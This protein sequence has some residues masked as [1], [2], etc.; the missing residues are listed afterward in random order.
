[1]RAWMFLPLLVVGCDDQLLEPELEGLDTGAVLKA[2]GLG[3]VNGDT[4]YCN[5]VAQLCV[6]G[7]GDCDKTTQCTAGLTCATDVGPDWGFPTGWDICEG[8]H[9][10]N[11]V[12]DGNE[13]GLDCG[14]SCAPC[15]G[16][17]SGVLGFGTTNSDRTGD[18]VAATDG[19]MYIVGQ[20]DGSLTLSPTVTLNTNGHTSI[21][22][23]KYNASGVLQWANTYTDATF[24]IG[25]SDLK[26][27]I[28]PVTKDVA[29]GG[30]FAGTVDFGA[31]VLTATNTD[32]FVVVMDANGN[33]TFAQ[34]YGTSGL[35]RVVDV[36]HDRL[37]NLYI[38]ALFAT[39]VNFGGATLNTAGLSDFG[40]GKLSSTNAHLYSL[41]FGNAN[42]DVPIDLVV[43]Q[44]LR[45]L[46]TS[47]YSG[48]LTVLGTNLVALGG[49]DIAVIRLTST[50]AKSFVKSF[51]G[52][53]S[54][55]SASIAVNALRQP[56][57]AGYFK[58]TVDFGAG[59]VVSPGASKSDAFLLALDAA[60]VH[61]WSRI[62]S[63]SDN[64]QG[65]IVFPTSTGGAAFG[66]FFRG[67]VTG[68][69]VDG[70]SA[71]A[72]GGSD[73]FV[74]VYDSAGTLLSATAFGGTLDDYSKAIG[75]Y[76]TVG[77]V[78]G[79]YR[80]S[81]TLGPTALNSVGLRDGF[82]AKFTGF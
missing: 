31:A 49:N 52:T 18:M 38:G 28:N 77:Y 26:L 34:K 15:G 23:A 54:D 22:L 70:S 42:A 32:G 81:M 53:N 58:G 9:C 35:D 45:L 60:G 37:G 4:D 46:A 55:T 67:T 21:F 19:S 59:P 71:V 29:M 48:T 63:S 25:D 30:S 36:T 47:T 43:D 79:D 56:Y 16:L 39:S 75:T 24:N 27:S 57:V 82:F 17:I 7:E 33:E 51:G 73:A 72:V 3:G 74:R 13:T 5:N 68:F 2:K 12:L 61:R 1:M 41:A 64:D 8:T 69:N 44:D 40:I 62:I 11:S 78:A 14:G 66:G 65:L 50:G 6:A 76:G 80:S 20:F 10:Q